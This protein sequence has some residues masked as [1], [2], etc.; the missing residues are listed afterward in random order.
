MLVLRAAASLVRM[1]ALERGHQGIGQDGLAGSSH[2]RLRE[3]VEGHVEANLQSPAL[4]RLGVLRVGQHASL[5][6][7]AAG[8]SE[9]H[10]DDVEGLHLRVAPPSRLRDRMFEDAKCRRA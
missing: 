1:C 6:E 9:Q 10:G 8:V 5:P 2:S 3:V 4:G 7:P